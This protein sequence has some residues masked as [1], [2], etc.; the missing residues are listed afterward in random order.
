MR[1]YKQTNKQT[2]EGGVGVIQLEITYPPDFHKHSVSSISSTS[3]LRCSPPQV[4]SA[5]G[6]LPRCE[7]QTSNIM[8]HKFTCFHIQCS[9][10][11]EMCHLRLTETMYRHFH[12]F[13]FFISLSSRYLRY[14]LSG[15]NSPR[16]GSPAVG[17]PSEPDCPSPTRA[18][19]FP[20]VGKRELRSSKP[21]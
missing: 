16:G 11:S 3:Y 14:I 10:P 17:A 4:A 13:F 5:N 19:L 21:H 12:F 7:G 15:N 2:G 8:T 20:V 18:I 6:K 9:R 1:C